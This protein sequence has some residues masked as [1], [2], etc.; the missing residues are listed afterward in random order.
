MPDV[1]AYLGSEEDIKELRRDMEFL[2][3]ASMSGVPTFIIGDEFRTLVGGQSARALEKAVLLSVKEAREELSA[4]QFGDKLSSTGTSSSLIHLAICSSDIW[5]SEQ[6]FADAI[7][8]I[9][10]SSESNSFPPYQWG[11][12]GLQTPSLRFRLSSDNQQ[13]LHIVAN[14]DTH[15][16][17]GRVAGQ[18][19]AFF[20]PSL[21]SF[22]DKVSRLSALGVSILNIERGPLGVCCPLVCRVMN[23]L[24]PVMH[25]NTTGN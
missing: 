8:L 7:G 3:S 12:M 24:P 20:V 9:P 16:T 19:V 13:E 11:F 1:H 14:D 2:S 23:A 10:V 15:C 21:A 5:R 4:S 17:Q 22:D 6:L 18:H 25:V